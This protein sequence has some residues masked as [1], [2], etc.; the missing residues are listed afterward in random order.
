[1]RRVEIVLL[2][3]GLL[4]L[5]AI[6]LQVGAVDVLDQL[7]Q[8]AWVLPLLLVG[9]GAVSQLLEA[10]AWR[11]AFKRDGL[12]I[13]ELFLVRLAGEAFN[14]TTPTANVGGEGVKA[15][16]LQDRVRIRD[17]VPSLLVSK[18]TDALGQVALLTIG[19]ALAWHLPQLD[20]RMFDGMMT[21]L[22]A[23]LVGVCGFVFVQTSGAVARGAWIFGKLGFLRRQS[24]ENATLHVDRALAR[25]YRRRRDR[26]LLSTACNLGAGLLGAVEVWV[27]V[28]VL[29]GPAPVVPMVVVSAIVSAISFVGFFVPGQIA[30]REGAYVAAFVALDMDPA[31]GLTVGLAKRVLD[32]GWAG[33][34]FVAL[35]R[36]RR[37]PPVPTEGVEPP[38]RE[39][40][41]AP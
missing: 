30:V 31:L 28:S 23:E 25:Y 39:P 17:V 15:W 9:P 41:P 22:A 35:A 32:L 4:G 18:T 33:I 11:Y 21:L 40:S 12:P 26:L 7:R 19:I 36:Y 34:G 37:R 27:I 5:G 14:M 6:L 8:I 24:T 20:T 10:Y 3:A 1:M 13:T 29:D 16:L 2:I 38:H